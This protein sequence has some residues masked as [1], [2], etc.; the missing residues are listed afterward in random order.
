MLTLEFT[1]LY[2]CVMMIISH[3]ISVVQ[4]DVNVRLDVSRVDIDDDNAGLNIRL[5]SPVD[6]DDANAG[7]NDPLVVLALH[8]AVDGRGKQCA[9]RRP[10]GRPIGPAE[11]AARHALHLEVDVPVLLRLDP[12]HHH[13]HRYRHA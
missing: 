9:G 11:P 3:A 4:E 12:E 7:L 10:D 13:R 2:W 6:I 8:A 1:S 5:V